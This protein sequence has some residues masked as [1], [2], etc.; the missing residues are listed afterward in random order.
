M[1]VEAGLLGA[2]AV[3]LPAPARHRDQQRGRELGLLA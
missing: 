1:M 3:F 2:S